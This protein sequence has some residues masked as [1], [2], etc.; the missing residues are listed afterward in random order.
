MATS[1]QQPEHILTQEQVESFYDNGYLHLKNILP[2]DTQELAESIINKWVNKKI[3]TWAKK[4]L[5]NEKF[6]QL[7]LETR[8]YQAW[9]AAG[10]PHYVPRITRGVF[11]ES[12]LQLLMNRTL[13]AI[14]SEIL[15]S[16]NLAAIYG[17]HCRPI[18]PTRHFPDINSDYLNTPWHQDDQYLPD[19]A[20]K[21]FV[22]FWIPLVDVDES[23]SCLCVAAGHHRD[24]IYEN[25]KIGLFCSIDQEV[26]KNFKNITP[27]RMKKGDLLC[28]H[29]RLPHYSMQN[30]TET[31]RWSFDMRYRK[32]AESDPAPDYGFICSHTDKSRVNTLN[33]EQLL[34]AF[35][36]FAEKHHVA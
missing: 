32:L 36:E 6:H 4:G 20:S 18:L 26:I 8:F 10:K 1:Q 34:K 28:M 15:G 12:M 2:T 25:H 5:L 27:I 9:L 24:K 21:A 22:V 29:Q 7:P 11:T 33:A 13:I 14:A 31:I 23:N 30:T 19:S 16:I 35:D 3:N 17:Y